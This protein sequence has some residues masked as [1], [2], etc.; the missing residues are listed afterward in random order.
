VVTVKL[1]KVGKKGR[2]VSFTVDGK[3]QKAK[4]SGG[5]TGIEINGVD[6]QRA[7]LKPGMSCEIAYPGNN[8]EATK[9]DCKT[10]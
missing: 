4:V 1:D 10:K 8:E 7:E 6:A 9:I 3:A 5:R 2:D